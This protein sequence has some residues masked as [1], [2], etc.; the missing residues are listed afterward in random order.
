[1][2]HYFPKVNFY[3]NAQ[4]LLMAVCLNCDQHTSQDVEVMSALCKMRLKS[5]H[6][7]NHYLSCVRELLVQNPD[8]LKTL[9]MHAVYNELSQSRNPNNMALLSTMFSQNSELAAKV[10]GINCL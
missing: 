4:E 3:K 7:L 10:C 5:K 2:S 6:I 9:V 1:M 8:N